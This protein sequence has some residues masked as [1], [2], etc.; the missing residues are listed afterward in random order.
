MAYSTEDRSLI[1]AAIE[2]Y[3]ETTGLRFV[4]ENYA[5]TPS[6]G[7]LHEWTRVQG[8][9][10]SEEA[11]TE[12]SKIEQR[13]KARIEAEIEPRL[14]RSLEALDGALE[15]DPPRSLDALRFATV[16]GIFTDKLVPVVKAVA[17]LIGNAQGVNILIAASPNP[18]GT[19]HRDVPDGWVEGEVVPDSPNAPRQPASHS[20]SD[21]EPGEGSGDD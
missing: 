1:L 19:E 8:L 10:A 16:T 18:P 2:R 9:E 12:L 21:G 15:A 6:R 11:R 7:T 5:L 17:P 3:G 20:L 4:K 13:R 14:Y